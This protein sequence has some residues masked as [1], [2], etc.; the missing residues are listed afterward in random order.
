MAKKETKSKSR[1]KKNA[2]IGIV[3]FIIRTLFVLFVVST[4]ISFVQIRI[5]INEKKVQLD[6]ITQKIAQEEQRNKE[7]KA[8]LNNGITDEYKAK[9]AREHGYSLPDERVYANSKNG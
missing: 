8:M 4:A 2:K 1:T 5:Q 6:E 7:L 9:I 3:N